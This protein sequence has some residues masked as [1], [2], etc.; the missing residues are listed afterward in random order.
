MKDNELE[1]I[2][3][4]YDY[5][6]EQLKTIYKEQKSNRDAILNEIAKILLTYTIVNDIIS[7]SMAD[8]KR[9]YERLS[10]I[11]MKAIN[12]E[13]ALQEKVLKDILT[14]TINKTFDY[15]SYNAK[16][17]DVRKIIEENFKG[18]HFSNRVWENE[19]EVAKH[20]HK[21]V[22]DFLN[23]KINVNQIKKEIEKT[24]NTSA[25]NAKRLT[26]TEVS[27]CSN[28]AF[29]RFCMETDVKKVRYVATLDSNLCSD[30]EQ[31]HDK[32]FDFNNKIDLPRHP[33]C[34]CF[35]TI[36]E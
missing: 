27:R 6:E 5:A 1:F 31:Y 21:Q 19:E 18:K 25:Y 15:Y 20:L 8:K 28:N 32:V 3:S 35:Y 26:E 2:K 10:R 33:L 29:H 14:N 23:G 22:N 4:L 16:L 17:N 13:G 34:R 24:F 9:E 30:C 12:G 36:E 7:L 11:I